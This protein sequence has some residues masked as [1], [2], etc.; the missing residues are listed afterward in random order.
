MREVDKKGLSM[1]EAC[2]GASEENVDVYLLVVGLDLLFHLELG[3]KFLWIDSEECDH[4][5]CMMNSASVQHFDVY[6]GKKKSGER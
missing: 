1:E 3:W 5:E 4:H 2:H 6:T